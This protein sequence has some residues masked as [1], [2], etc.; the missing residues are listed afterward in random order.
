MVE[1][2]KSC[3]I[4]VIYCI[5]PVLLDLII[6]IYFLHFTFIIYT[7][8]A[9]IHFC[10]GFIQHLCHAENSSPLFGMITI[11]HF[12]SFWNHSWI[13]C[14]GYLMSR[15]MHTCVIN[16]LFLLVCFDFKESIFEKLCGV[17]MEW[18]VRSSKALSLSH[19]MGFSGGKPS[20][21]LNM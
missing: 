3:K 8:S 14:T 10:F 15:V 20:D 1:T 11:S 2:G 21:F 9:F 19:F 13:H 4:I 17:I 7:F 12:I 5:I 16:C 18:F 6:I